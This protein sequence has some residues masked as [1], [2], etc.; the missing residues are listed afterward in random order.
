M[1]P[2]CLPSTSFRSFGYTQAPSSLHISISLSL[3]L[4]LCRAGCYVLAATLAGTSR[5]VNTPHVPSL[6]VPGLLLCMDPKPSPYP[7]HNHSGSLTMELYPR[8]PSVRPYVR[9]FAV[10]RRLLSPSSFQARFSASDKFARQL[11][12]RDRTVTKR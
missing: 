2:S 10:R 7:A 12:S 6:Y 9:P 8:N 5:L 3:P 11:V 1:F 4:S